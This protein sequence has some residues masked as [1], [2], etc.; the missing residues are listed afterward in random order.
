[1]PSPMAHLTPWWVMWQV[2][3]LRD[4]GVLEGLLRDGGLIVDRRAKEALALF[5]QLAEQWRERARRRA[6]M[7]KTT[8]FP[9]Q[10]LIS[11]KKN[12]SVCSSLNSRS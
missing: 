6:Y 11:L 5:A 7:K 12:L 3:S 2:G 4:S 8:L 9:K 10:L 1:M